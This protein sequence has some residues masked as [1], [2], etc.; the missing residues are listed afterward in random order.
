MSVFWVSSHVGVFVPPGGDDLHFLNPAEPAA[1][2]SE[3]PPTWSA[4]EQY[5]VSFILD[6]HAIRRKEKSKSWLGTL[7]EGKELLEIADPPIQISAAGEGGEVVDVQGEQIE[8]LDGG[9][10]NTP[11]R[12]PDGYK[13]PLT[14]FAKW[15]GSHGKEKTASTTVLVE[16]AEN[17]KFKLLSPAKDDFVIAAFADLEIKWSL[18]KAVKGT[19]RVS[20]RHATKKNLLYESTDVLGTATTYT[21]PWLYLRGDQ[22]DGRDLLVI[23]EFR[24]S[25][26]AEWFS[27]VRKVTVESPTRE[28]SAHLRRAARTT[29]GD[30][31]DEVSGAEVL[32]LAQQSDRSHEGF[33]VELR[34][35]MFAGC[36]PN[37]KYGMFGGLKAGGA[38]RRISG[39]CDDKVYC[40]EAQLYKSFRNIIP[41]DLLDCKT[42]DGSNGW[43][44][45]KLYN[46]AR[47]E[48][49]TLESQPVIA[50]ELSKS[51]EVLPS[52]EKM[53]SRIATALSLLPDDI[54]IEDVQ[55]M[56][57]DAPELIFRLRRAVPFKLTPELVQAAVDSGLISFEDCELIKPMLSLVTGSDEVT[58]PAPSTRLLSTKQKLPLAALSPLLVT[59]GTHGNHQA[60]VASNDEASLK[61]QNTF[62]VS[63]VGVKSYNAYYWDFQ[64]SQFLS[65]DV[66]LWII[67]AYLLLNNLRKCPWPCF[68]SL[69]GCISKP[70]SLPGGKRRSEDDIEL[71]GHFD[72]GMLYPDLAQTT[73]SFSEAVNR[74]I[75]ALETFSE[76][77]ARTSSATAAKANGSRHG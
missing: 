57:S 7:V 42:N 45:G 34:K 4:G 15:T 14:I 6:R 53:K 65:H 52:T 17:S 77:S 59:I 62:A 18:G 30:P 32:R 61:T 37:S 20:L 75:N 19:V 71:S 74:R 64:H 46:C 22:S 36:A 27:I 51:L 67:V 44:R 26:S 38:L 54:S 49:P 50:L 56:M 76:V 2:S 16:P 25:N 5:M 70:L 1:G 48:E 8:S 33:A 39:A 13:G 31:E 3:K 43:C 10:D 55:K 12:V 66:L 73:G 23:V 60:L 63:V 28:S 69:C 35:G 24:D 47:G 40:P 58:T 9:W 72:S 11:I 29:D 21:L 68:S 41:N